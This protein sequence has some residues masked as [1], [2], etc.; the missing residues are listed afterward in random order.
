MQ[1]CWSDCSSLKTHFRDEFLC[2][3]AQ[4]L[5]LNCCLFLQ[6]TLHL[7][8]VLHRMGIGHNDIKWSNILL[9]NEWPHDKGQGIN[10]VLC[11]FGVSCWEG[12]QYVTALPASI[13]KPK[14]KACS[15][16]AKECL[17]K[18]LK[19][20][21]EVASSSLGKQVSEQAANTLPLLTPVTEAKLKEKMISDQLLLLSTGTPGYRNETMVNLSY[22]MDKNL[23]KN[24]N[25]KHQV[26]FVDVCR[27]DVRSVAAMLCEVMRTKSDGVWAKQGR[28]CPHR[29]YELELDK[30]RTQQDVSDFLFQ[31]QSLP[32]SKAS[33]QTQLLCT[34]VKE[35]LRSDSNQL[36]A[37]DAASHEFFSLALGPR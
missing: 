29:Q 31:E 7:V 22:Q 9:V 26:N 18:A 12:T 2:D 1:S 21:T 13:P 23:R 11:D 4:A 6:K 33:R 16:R 20:S 3:G 35:M 15:S 14:A 5:S 25:V 32:L 34:L 17:K 10:I 24:K 30:L 36:S 8:S 19:T 37:E 28:K 27:H